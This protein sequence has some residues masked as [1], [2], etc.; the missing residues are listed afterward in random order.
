[1]VLFLGNKWYLPEFSPSYYTSTK[2]ISSDISV[3]TPLDQAITWFLESCFSAS[4]RSPTFR[5]LTKIAC[6]SVK[7]I[8]GANLSYTWEIK[9][10]VGSPLPLQLVPVVVP[11]WVQHESQCLICFGEIWVLLE[12]P[13]TEDDHVLQDEVCV[14]N[15]HK[16]ATLWF[17]YV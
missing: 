17:S 3:M 10:S 15:W 7:S 13:Q 2:S 9:Y 8:S 5:L 1:M 16:Q 14:L 4:T 6:S 12:H 11:L